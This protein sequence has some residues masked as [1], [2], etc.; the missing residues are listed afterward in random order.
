VRILMLAPPGGGKGTQGMRVAREFG[1][2]HISSGELLRAA[3]AQDTPIGR[4]VAQYM[5]TGRLAPDAVVTEAVKPVLA[6]RDGYV[7]DGYPRNLEQSEGLDF[8]HVIYLDVPD[9]VVTERLLARGREDDKREVIRARLK[10]YE[11]DTEPLIEHYR[12]LG[13]LRRV[14]GDRPADDITAEL[15]EL[16]RSS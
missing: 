1:L 4:E 15:I 9:D 5:A 10:Q 12:E 6:E 14:D 8:D 16:V 3:V 11:A 2:E 13:V 7:L